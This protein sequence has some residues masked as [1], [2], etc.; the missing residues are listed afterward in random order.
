MTLYNNARQNITRTRAKRKAGYFFLA[1]S[2]YVFSDFTHSLVVTKR[3]AK[4]QHLSSFSILTIYT[5]FAAYD[6]ANVVVKATRLRLDQR[7]R[8]L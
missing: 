6:A 8:R 3:E 7:L 2:V 1:H 5:K 4:F